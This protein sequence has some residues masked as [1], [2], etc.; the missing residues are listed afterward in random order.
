MS[1]RS[2]KV[3]VENHEVLII[4]QRKRRQFGWCPG[5]DLEVEMVTA[6]QAA[7]LLGTSLRAICR[8]VEADQFHFRETDDGM[9]YLCLNSLL[10]SPGETAGSERCVATESLALKS[11]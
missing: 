6:E 1:K 2:T 3:T 5:C 9:L 11:A 4:R 7:V 10:Q 8:R